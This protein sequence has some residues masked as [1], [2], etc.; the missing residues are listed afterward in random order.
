MKLAA[1]LE[2]KAFHEVITVSPDTTILDA[3]RLMN[4]YN[5]GSLLVLTCGS[6][7]IE[8]IIT[9][10]DILRLCAEDLDAVSTSHVAEIMTS[11]LITAESIM[12][13]LDAVKL[14]KKHSI[15]HLPVFEFNKLTGILAIE[16][17]IEA[18]QLQEEI[19]IHSLS[20]YLG[21]AYGSHVY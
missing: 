7:G 2:T 15:R 8:G 3:I 4:K 21:G 6:E 18:V 1:V 12:D 17:L 9:E 13:A 14:M 11:D 20:D 19:T 5:I 10:R 16:D